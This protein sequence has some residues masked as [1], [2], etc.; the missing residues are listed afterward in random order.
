LSREARAG[1]LVVCALAVVLLALVPRPTDSPLGRLANFEGDGPDPR[2]D[3]PLDARA[4]RRAGRLVPDDETYLAA[5]PGADPLLQGN[6]KAAAQL[7]LTP[8]LPVQSLETAQWV[9]AYLEGEPEVPG[10][11]LGSKLWLFDAEARP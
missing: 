1:V 8:S 4:L 9:L 6:L 7:Y 10:R 3:S 11:R 2:F 5:A